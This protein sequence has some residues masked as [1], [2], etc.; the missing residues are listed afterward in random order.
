MYDKISKSYAE[1]C[2][3]KGQSPTFYGFIKFGK[4]NFAM[5]KM[6]FSYL[7]CGK[8]YAWGNPTIKGLMLFE[9]Q[10]ANQI[11]KGVVEVD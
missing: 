10:I 5:L 4:W 6:L 1:E 2:K 8:A 11:R 7:N 9:K 3:Q